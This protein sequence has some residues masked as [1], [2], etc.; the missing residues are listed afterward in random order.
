MWKRPDTG[1]KVVWDS[2][3][4]GIMFFNQEPEDPSAITESLSS[5]TGL[6]IKD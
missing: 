2:P 5:G 3:H 6:V 1:R 4:C